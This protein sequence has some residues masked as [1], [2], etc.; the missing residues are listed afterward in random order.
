M[1]VTHAT[2]NYPHTYM[3]HL[4]LWIFDDSGVRRLT[5]EDTI[6]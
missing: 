3:D 6:E 4:K 5:F 1:C 2:V